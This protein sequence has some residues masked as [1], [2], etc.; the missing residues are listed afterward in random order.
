V[1]SDKP[2]SAGGRPQIGSDTGWSTVTTTGRSCGTKADGAMWCW[3]FGAA[4]IP[5]L[6]TVPV[7]VK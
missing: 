3:G 5:D 1:V 6:V 7:P 4:A 2:G